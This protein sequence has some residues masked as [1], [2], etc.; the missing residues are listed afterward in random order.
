MTRSFQF[1]TSLRQGQNRFYSKITLNFQL[2]DKIMKTSTYQCALKKAYI[3]K[4]LICVGIFF[5][6]SASTYALGVCSVSRFNTVPLITVGVNPRQVLAGDLNGDN[7]RDLVVLTGSSSGSNGVVT[8]LLNNGRG[9]FSPFTSIPLNFTAGSAT[10]ADFNQ[11]GIPDLAVNG[12][13]GFSSGASSVA[14]FINNGDGVFSLQTTLSVQGSSTAVEA[15]DFNRDGAIDIAV[16]STTNNNFGIVALFLNDGF[17]NFSLAGNFS[18]GGNPRDLKVA[19]FNG[20]GVADVLTINNNSTGSL[21]LGNASGNFQVATNFFLSSN[22]STFSSGLVAVGDLNNDGK[23]D[24]VVS[25]LDSNFFNVLLNNGGSFSVPT[26]TTFTDPNL[27]VRS[28]ALAQ[29]VGDGNLDLVIGVGGGFSESISQVAIFQGNGSGSIS[30][31]S[32]GLTPT[33]SSPVAL[34]IADLNNDGRNDVVTANSTS[35]DVSVLIN[36]NDAFG[37]NTF[38]TNPLP[39]VIAAADFN[40]DGNLDTITGATQSSGT[41]S[42]LSISFGNGAGGV[43]GAQNFSGTGPI[44]T[45]IATDLNNDSRPDLIAAVTN[46]SNNFNTVNVY[47][48]SGNNAALFTAFASSSVNVN[49]SI[50]NLI[51]GDFNNDG[52]KDIVASSSNTNSIALLPG[53]ANGAFSSFTSFA[54]PVTAPVVA[55]GNFNNDSNLDLAV[56]GTNS[57][58]GVGAIFTLLGNGNGA[59]SQVSESVPVT[60]PNSIASGDFN[61]DS[62]SDVAVTSPQNNFSSSSTSVLIAFGIGGGR[63]A[64][65]I[66]Y[67]VG[68]DARAITAA[69]FNGDR[70]LDLIVVNRGSNSFSV[71]LN[72]GNGNFSLASNFL[73]GILPESLAVG[74]FNNDGRNEVVTANR[75]GNNFS[76]IANLCQ[77]AVTKTDYNAEGRSDFAVFRPSSGT[78]FVL[79]N[80]L[81]DVRSQAFG[82]STD[83]PTPGDYDGDGVTDFAVFR[84]SNGTW[85]IFRSSTNRSIAVAFGASG[86][87]PVA[88]DYD[89]DG[90]TDIAVYRP[91]NGTWYIRRGSPTQTQFNAFQFG[92]SA[93]RP[94][95]ADYDG[96]GRADLAVYRA[97]TW[98]VL[99]SSNSSVIFQPFGSA[100]DVPVVGDYDGD[101]KSDFAVYRVGIWYVLESRTNSVRAETFGMA[102]DRPQPAD[103]DGDNRTDVAVF[104]PSEGNWY[105]LRSSD[106]QLRSVTFGTSGDIPVASLYRY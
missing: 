17:G 100:D 72:L 33:G 88:N 61:G 14:L 50:R 7:A 101:G 95:P 20:D 80:D 43:S 99:R 85:Y 79:S 66:S 46:S 73:A 2:K 74:D 75:G 51:V 71:L 56:A 90:R 92:N 22:T 5:S 104:R 70:R 105:V 67:A 29:V 6:L 53:A 87:I 16:A 13:S 41:P 89:G 45:I 21:L 26:Q 24:L 68:I 35:G 9:N 103:Y 37:P 60:N 59:F 52:R 1:S 32:P 30:P 49:F 4:V 97:G 77:E 96:D 36:N 58:S 55:A 38:P 27:R 98:I 93:D 3:F 42:M 94:V 19:D 40:G 28:L 15:G 86:D 11:D 10:L 23:P 47:L 8:V 18:I 82:N 102:N 65:P 62:I 48:N 34:T 63:F 39:G 91:S 106:R 78:W 83:I 57:S 12:T 84:P 31:I 64:Q 81:R 44:Q 76:L 25:N 54:S 69:D